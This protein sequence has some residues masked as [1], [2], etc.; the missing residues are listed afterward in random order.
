MKKEL[1]KYFAAT[2][3]QNVPLT[4]LNAKKLPVVITSRYNLLKGAIFDKDVCFA[5]AKYQTTPLG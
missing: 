2:L 4:S 1:Q 3:C 5:C